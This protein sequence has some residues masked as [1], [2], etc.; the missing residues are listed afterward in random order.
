MKIN[1][2]IVG[3]GNVGTQ[4]VVHFAEKGYNVI[5]YTSNPQEFQS[6]LFIVD[7]KDKIIHTATDY[8]I[9]NSPKEAFLKADIIFITVPA[10]AIDKIADEIYPYVHKKMRIV[11]IPGT[12]G[13]EWFF[14]KH[15]QKGIEL[16]GLQ[17]VPSVARL[18]K[19]GSV[20][21][22]VG[23]RSDLFIGGIASETSL[24]VMC[25]ILFEVFNIKCTPLPNYLSVTLTPS[26]PILHTARL[27]NLF[28]DYYDGKVYK[29]ISL[30][31]ED[32][33]DDVSKILFLMDTELQN[34]CQQ[35]HE[36]DLKSVVSLK[37]HY[38]SET[39]QQLTKKIK[40]IEGFKGLKTPMLKIADGYIPD[41]NS[42]YFIADFPFG[43]NILVQIAGLIGVEC[44]SMNKVMNWYIN[45]RPQ[46]KSFSFIDFGI[47]ER[48]D[49]IEYYL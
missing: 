35:L 41:F 45:Q 34:I 18:V 21:R 27:Y 39:P 42:R 23:Y 44:P 19:Y 5:L 48:K 43:L 14:K 46:E 49:F 25:K 9:T 3:G 38:E 4:F 12:G 33:N 13:I 26:N 29:N 37:K 47:K 16:F 1:I 11:C 30:F 6:R 7:S 32:W 20:V 8:T 36:F 31:Y 28:S 17:R 24:I 40:S 15:I 22:C 10:F 2:T